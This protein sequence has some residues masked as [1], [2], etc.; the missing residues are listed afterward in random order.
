M[1][2]PGRVLAEL[3]RLRKLEWRLRARI[4]I[5]PVW[6]KHRF[7]MGCALVA[8]GSAREALAVE[9][10]IVVG[11]ED[12]GRLMERFVEILEHHAGGLEHQPP[13]TASTSPA[14]CA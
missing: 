3:E 12:R 5:D 2:S 8:L 9:P 4:E 7:V 10:E 13:S 11:F 1:P 14:C 6:S